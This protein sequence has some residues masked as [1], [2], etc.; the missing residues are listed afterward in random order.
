MTWDNLENQT[1]LPSCELADEAS[2][3]LYKLLSTAVA[4]VWLY[5]YN[6]KPRPPPE[7]RN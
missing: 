2:H 3:F 5:I 1:L 4:P 6:T 7:T